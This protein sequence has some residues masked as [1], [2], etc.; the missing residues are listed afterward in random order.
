MAW[1]GAGDLRYRT[2]WFCYLDLLGFSTLVDSGAVEKIIPTYEGVVRELEAE[3]G[4]KAGTGVSSSW[5]SDTFIIFSRHATD[6]EFAAVES[7][8][9][10]FFQRLIMKDIP[11]RGALTLGKLYSRTKK[12]IFVGPA[13]IDAYTYGEKQNWLGFLLTPSVFRH[14]QGTHLDLDNRPHYRPLG[15]A[16]ILRELPSEHVYAYAFNNGRVA[17]K[18]P[19][20]DHLA[21]MR[22]TAGP[23][24][25]QKYDNTLAFARLH[26]P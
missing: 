20:L 19:F 6:R 5:F 25:H 23:A 3:V 17:G 14:F 18:N 12:N 24:H 21:A 26:A 10:L 16:R 22:S 9:R 2:R 4:V 15:D 11:V 1:R 8:A 7:V 13:L